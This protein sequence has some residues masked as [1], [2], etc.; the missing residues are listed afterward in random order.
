M[1]NKKVNKKAIISFMD[2]FYKK[3]SIALG[4]LANE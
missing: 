3:N 4:K 2:D 1:K